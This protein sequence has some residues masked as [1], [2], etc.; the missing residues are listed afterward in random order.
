MHALRPEGL[1]AE[2]G[3]DRGVDSPGDGDDDLAEPV[4]LDVVAQSDAEEPDALEDLG[5]DLR[6]D[7]P[8]RIAVRRADGQPLGRLHRDALGA[9]RR[10]M[11]ALRA[12]RP[13]R[14]C[15][16]ARAGGSTTCRLRSWRRSWS[17]AASSR[18]PAQVLDAATEPIT[19]GH[20]AGNLW[21]RAEIEVLLAEGRLDEALVAAETHARPDRP[22]RQPQPRIRGAR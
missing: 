6:R 20:L 12:R 4:L 5:S 8:R 19:A 21:R 11:G 9:P 17:S 22:P 14:E 16:G 7:L 1:G 10:R 15:C 18:P 2:R 13:S 3:R